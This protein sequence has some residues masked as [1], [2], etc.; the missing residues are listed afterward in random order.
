MPDAQLRLEISNG[1]AEQTQTVALGD[2]VA[3]GAVD[4]AEAER[5]SVDPVGLARLFETRLARAVEPAPTRPPEPGPELV[6]A[7]A[8]GTRVMGG[9]LV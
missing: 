3:S 9:D 5:V 7:P 8:P 1:I 2:L 6:P 4:P